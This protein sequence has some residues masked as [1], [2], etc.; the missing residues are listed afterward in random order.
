MD[1]GPIK[2]DPP[3][4]DRGIPVMQ[5]LKERR[6][7]R[8][9]S[10]RKLSRQQL[11]EL[12]WAA[13]DV[14]REDGK[15]TAPSAQN[16]HIVDVYV[17]LQ[18]GIYF[19]DPAGHQLSPLVE[20]DFRKDTGN[21]D[22]V[23]NAPVNLIYVADLDKLKDARI[24]A[25]VEEE[26]KWAYVEAGHKAENVYI[27]CASEGLGA[28]TRMLRDREKLGSVMKLRPEQAVIS[29]QTVGYCEQK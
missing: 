6:S 25:P 19:Y 4:L 12:L 20:G 9:F 27:Y 21:Q 7:E 28:R 23:C 15:R 14:N 1:T 3:R 22:Y 17:V 29:A 16:K 26:M 5:A 24:P 8:E 11:S 10:N 18:D 13:N 2:L